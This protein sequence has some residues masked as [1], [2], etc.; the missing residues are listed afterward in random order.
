MNRWLAHLQ[1]HCHFVLFFSILMFC[2]IG[3]YSATSWKCSTMCLLLHSSP[4]WS[5]SFRA[6]RT[7][8]KGEVCPFRNAQASNFSFFQPLCSSC[9]SVHAFSLIWNTWNLRIFIRYWGKIR[10]WG[11]H[12]YQN[13]A[14]NESNLWT[15]QNNSFLFFG[16][17]KNYFFY[18]K[19]RRWI[20]GIFF[21][22]K[23]F[24]LLFNS[25]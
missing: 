22:N 2:T 1:F 3:R 19:N 8:T 20:C 23:V 17:I 14:L 7:G 12:F 16:I 6:S 4:F 9:L 13:K 15:H 11:Y 18:I 21:M 5:T 10:I 25:K 24:I